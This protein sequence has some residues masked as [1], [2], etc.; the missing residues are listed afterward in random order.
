ME[1]KDNVALVTG[2]SGGLGRQICLSLANAGAHLAVGYNSRHGEAQV[3]A[4][5]VRDI[6]VESEPLRCDLTDRQQVESLV[7]QTMERFGRVDILVNNAGYNKWIPFN[8]L[9]ALNFEEWEKIASINLTGPMLLTK[10]V[11]GPMRRQGVGRIVNIASMAGLA[12]SGSSIAYAVSKA[13]LIHL[14]RCMAVAL[15]PEVLV[16]CIAPGLLEGTRMAANLDPAHKRRAKENAAL[17]RAVDLDDVADQ[18]VAFCRTDST[19][20]QT[21]VMDAGRFYH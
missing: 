17:K 14:T 2:A 4:R 10:A 9:E 6:G 8:D 21:L 19:T 3:T 13:G 12:P 11:A 5:K 20:G 16:N 7:S 1:L 15:G 18:V